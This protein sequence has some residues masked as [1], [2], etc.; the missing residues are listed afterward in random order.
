MYLQGHSFPWQARTTRVGKRC[1]LS[2]ALLIFVLTA[3]GI[4]AQHRASS[5]AGAARHGGSALAAISAPTDADFTIAANTAELSLMAGMQVSTTVSIQFLGTLTGSVSL[6]ASNLPPGVSANFAPASVSGTGM[7]EVSFFA[8]VATPSAVRSITI[9]GINGTITHSLTIALMVQAAGGCECGPACIAILASAN[10]VTLPRGGSI[11]DIIGLS[12]VQQTGESVALS[13][14]DIPAGVSA[15]VD[16]LTVDS[17]TLTLTASNTAPLGTFTIIVVG[18]FGTSNAAI[19][20]VVTIVDATCHISYDIVSQWNNMFEAV[21][22]IDNTGTT[23]ISPGW[24]L[25]WSFANGQTISQLWNGT[26]M[27][28]AANVA[29]AGDTNIPVGGSDK[30]VGFLGTTMSNVPNQ[31]PTTF[32]LNEAPCSVN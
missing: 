15:S 1:A 7:V 31:V 32:T 29:V 28:A 27:Q 20:I 19:P 14:L 21:L 4:F 12:C 17:A 22:S 25:A 3:P 23:P 8:Q 30:G 26:V 6:S 2:F 18:S 9:T 13:L 16:N 5:F 11:T 24:T 10:G